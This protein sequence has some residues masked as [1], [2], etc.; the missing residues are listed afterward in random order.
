MAPLAK[1]PARYDRVLKRFTA[2][3]NTACPEE[4]ERLVRASCSPRL[5]VVSPYGIHRGIRAQLDSIAQVRAQFPRLKSGGTVLGAHHR[6]VLSAWWTTF[7]GA[8]PSLTGIDCY[9]FDG[10]SKIVRVVSFSPVRP[11]G[12]P[13]KPVATGRSQKRSS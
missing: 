4:R 3:W 6:V 12:G 8:R 2:A 7:G 10:R 11:Q 9:E 1:V 5:E 13:R